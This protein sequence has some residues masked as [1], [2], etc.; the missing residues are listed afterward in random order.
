MDELGEE[1]IEL[2]IRS[3][4]SFSLAE[5][6]KSPSIVSEEE[7]IGDISILIASTIEK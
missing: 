5:E 1:S 3:E 4:D 7:D 2:E 6:E